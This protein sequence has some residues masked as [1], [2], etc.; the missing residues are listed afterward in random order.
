MELLVS[1]TIVGML[2]G[3]ANAGLQKVIS[4]SHQ[5]VEISAGRN[6]GQALL[7]HAQENNGSILTGYLSPQDSS[8]GQT[9]NDRGQ[10]LSPSHAACS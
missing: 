2:A 3:L 7:L 4:A 9:L 1:I 5:A 8:L 6:M 10:P